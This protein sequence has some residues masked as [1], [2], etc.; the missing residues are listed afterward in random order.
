MEKCVPASYHF[1]SSNFSCKYLTSC[2]VNFRNGDGRISASARSGYGRGILR[3]HGLYR[4]EKK[5]R[6]ATHPGYSDSKPGQT[7]F[8]PGYGPGGQTQQG[9]FLSHGRGHAEQRKKS[10]SVLCSTHTVAL[11]HMSPAALDMIENFLLP[12]PHH[13]WLWMEN[14]EVKCKVGAYE[15]KEVNATWANLNISRILWDGQ[16]T[17]TNDAPNS[18]YVQYERVA[19]ADLTRALE[20]LDRSPRQTVYV[21]SSGR[22]ARRSPTPQSMRNKRR[23]LF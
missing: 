13:M 23:R 14:E 20:K 22:S 9:G 3:S 4:S 15:R 16:L 8:W 7:T 11:D 19:Y 10:S 1:G 21:P 12:E 17:R 6:N 18:V 5:P 2:L